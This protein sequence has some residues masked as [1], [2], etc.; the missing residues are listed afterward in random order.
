MR[1]IVF[2]VAV[3][4]V[5]SLGMAQQAPKL[6][7]PAAEITAMIAK[8]KAERK[9]DQAN[10]LQTIVQSSGYVARLEYRVAEVKA[11]PT[12]H[13]TEAEMFYV[14]DGAATVTTG[15]KLHDEKRTN[16]TNLSGSG[17]D[18]GTDRRVA[19]GDFFIVPEKTPHGFSQIDGTL[20]LMTIHLPVAAK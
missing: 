13:E 9:A 14:V 17:I 10:F 5:A 11:D 18:G 19:K 12:V 20:V 15:G 1:F 16:P 6:S 2:I 4:C 3:S 8:A 7:T